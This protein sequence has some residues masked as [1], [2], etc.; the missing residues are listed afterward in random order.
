MSREEFITFVKKIE[1]NILL[2][3][4]L[5]QCKTSKDL[6]FLQKNTDTTLQ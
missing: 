4:K 2:K 1:H 5:S 3:E 6:I